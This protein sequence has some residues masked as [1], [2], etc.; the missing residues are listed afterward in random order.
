MRRTSDRRGE[1]R[2]EVDH[3][4]TFEHASTGTPHDRGMPVT[5]F[6]AVD[7]EMTPPLFALHNIFLTRIH[8]ASTKPLHIQHNR[9][10]LHS[11][12]GNS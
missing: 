6:D 2:H 9:I 1:V 11:L 3:H 4:P 12:F 5:N 8:A 7:L 10:F